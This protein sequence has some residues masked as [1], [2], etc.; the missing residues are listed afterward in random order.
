MSTDSLKVWHRRQWH[1]ALM[2]KKQNKTTKQTTLSDAGKP[3]GRT[4]KIWSST[5]WS[6]FV[7]ISVWPGV[8]GGRL[9]E[10]FCPCVATFQGVMKAAGIVHHEPV[11]FWQSDKN[12]AC[13]NVATIYFSKAAICSLFGGYIRWEAPLAD[14]PTHLSQVTVRGLHTLDVQRIKW[15]C[16]MFFK[17]FTTQI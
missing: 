7:K 13:P 16:G 4:L 12:P 14:Q 10:C 9:V 2:E 1:S 5:K 15:K 17:V 6:K 8:L 11:A 3:E